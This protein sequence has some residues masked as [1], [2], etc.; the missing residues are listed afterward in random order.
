MISAPIPWWSPLCGIAYPAAVLLA[1]ALLVGMRVP[2]SPRLPGA[3]AVG[4]ALWAAAVHWVA[5]V[6]GGFYAGLAWGAVAIAGAACAWPDARRGWRPLIRTFAGL[7]GSDIALCMVGLIAVAPGALWF[8][9]HDKTYSLYGHFYITNDLLNGV[10][11]PRDPVFPDHV[12]LYHYGID[13]I[14]A[15]VAAVLP[16]GVP[17]SFSLLVLIL[18][19]C[20][21][22]LA[23][24]LARACG[25]REWSHRAAFI[26][27]FAGGLPWL[28]TFRGESRTDLLT[29]QFTSGQIMISPPLVNYFFQHPWTIGLPLMLLQMLILVRSERIWSTGPAAIAGIILLGW[30][31]GFC[32]TT[33]AAMVVVCGAASLAG[34]ARRALAR[35][36]TGRTMA[37]LRPALL[38]TGGYLVGVAAGTL[39]SGLLY[40][41]LFVETTSSG[42]ALGALILAPLSLAGSN[43]ESLVWILLSCGILF[44]VGL[45]GV[46]LLP[47]GRMIFI[48]GLVFAIVMPMMFRFAYSWDIVKFLAAGMVLAAFPC[49]AVYAWLTRR[50]S[51][52]IGSIAGLLLTA[53]AC[54]AGI[55]WCVGFGEMG[56]EIL[57]NHD[58]WSYR[59]TV[60]W[61][62]LSTDDLQAI[63][64]MRAHVLPR[65]LV[66]VPEPRFLGYGIYGGLPQF[67]IDPNGEI[68][69]EFRKDVLEARSAR[70]A[71]A[72]QWPSEVRW[73][74]LRS[75]Q[76]PERALLVALEQNRMAKAVAEFGG[77]TVYQRLEAPG[78]LSSAGAR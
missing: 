5:L 16:I 70:A 10:Y 30:A 77:V 28:A 23:V 21:I 40:H 72:G 36:W 42:T 56:V 62:D 12:L 22:L 67:H 13:L 1:N 68:F 38:I 73:F 34:T 3:I 78:S 75:A 8:D 17:W 39:S 2:P 18:W 20:T 54:A 24:A 49:V 47:R 15:M 76:P 4:F 53:G 31:S 61:A 11:P 19:P 48:T 66:Y 14:A 41:V 43:R 65:D 44:P 55:A 9:F 57:V 6:C 29:G 71:E 37:A 46:R 25:L 51:G 60:G 26:M 69:Q 27:A 33:V 35:P 52:P 58:F 59:R 7:S 45:A 74:V 64:W 32:N 63:P 50:K